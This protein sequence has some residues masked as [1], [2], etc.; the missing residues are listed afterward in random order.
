MVSRRIESVSGSA[1][2]HITEIANKLRQSGVDVINFS[3]GEP[4]FNTPAHICEAAKNA[5]DAGETHYTPAAGILELK[6]VIAEKLVSENHIQIEPSDVVVTPGAKQAIFE[7][8]FTVLDE[9][10]EAES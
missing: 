8:L 5:L 2:L 4:D 9:G 7:T 1:T 10:D 6:E 3:L